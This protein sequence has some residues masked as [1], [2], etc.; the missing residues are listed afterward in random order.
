MRNSYALRLINVAERIQKELPS[1]P[2]A[3]VAL[4]GVA[5]GLDAD[6]EPPARRAPVETWI[7]WG[8]EQLD[9]YPTLSEALVRGGQIMQ[10]AMSSIQVLQEADGAAGPFAAGSQRPS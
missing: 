2:M 1:D 6:V 5:L 9:R 10:E 8:E 4:L 3:G 7:A